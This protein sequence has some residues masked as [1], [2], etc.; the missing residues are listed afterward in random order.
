MADSFEPTQFGRYI[1]LDKLAVGGMAEIYRAKTYGVDGFEKLLA[2]K[3]IL[4]HCSADKDFITM[5]VDEA[6]L[7]VLLSHANIVQVYDLGKVG[8]DYFISMEFI[9]GT[10]LREMLNRC[11]VDDKRLLPEEV[12]VY[13]ISEICKGL[14]YAH[15]KTDNDGNPLNIVHRDVSPQNILISYEGEVKIVDFGIAKAALNV[16]HTM[17]GILKGKIA[18]MSPEQALGKPMDGRTDIFSAGLILYEALTGHKFFSGDTQFEVL[19]HIRSTHIHPEDLSSEIPDTLK[20]IL[21]KALAYNPKDR[22]QSAGDFQLD[23]TKFLYSTHSDFSPRQL[24]TLLSQLFEKELKEK[25]REREAS[26]DEKTRSVMIQSSITS[27]DIVVHREITDIRGKTREIEDSGLTKRE[28]KTR[29]RPF[30]AVVGTLFVLVAIGY[31]GWNLALK[32]MVKNWIVQTAS[33]P[34]TEMTTP[35][36]EEFEEPTVD[37]EETPWRNFGSIKVTTNPEGV[38]IFLNN[39]AT[40]LTSP[41]TLTK[42]KVGDKYA[43]RLSKE[44]Y[45]TIEETITVD[46]NKEIAL[47]KTLTPLPLGVI[48]ITSEPKGAQIFIN[49]QY[50]GQITPSRI[51]NLSLNTPHIVRLSLANHQDWTSSITLKNFDPLDLTAPLKTIPQ[52][53]APPAPTVGILT[54]QSNPEGARVSINGQDMG[55]TTPTSIA[56]ITLGYYY[57]IVLKREGYK[58]W[59]QSFKMSQEQPPPLVAN[60]EKIPE[61]SPQVK[62]TPPPPQKKVEPKPEP[63]YVSRSPEP[64]P[65]IPPSRIEKP[66]YQEPPSTRVS[67]PPGSL[68]IK[69]DPAGAEVYINSEYRGVT[70]LTVNDVSPGTVK[71][72][73]S[74]DGYLSYRSSLNLKPG[75][76]Q[77]LGDIKLG[78]RFGEV[79]IKSSPPGAIVSFDGQRIGARTPVTI[80]KVPRDEKHSVKIDLEGYQSWSKTFDL[81]TEA[82]KIY[83]VVL[84]KM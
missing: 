74:K 69:S 67:G 33:P 72:M 63:K 64:E 55:Q 39:E 31:L 35:P 42:L 80:R 50:T 66:V 81:N 15:R 18:Y 41:T 10:N 49:E 75:S 20:V 59:E 23:L 70:P 40:N 43:L 9:Y 17:A 53:T 46:S 21:A 22:Y 68:K 1:L 26:L 79:R 60:L 6:K 5:L 71:I 3:R 73:V 14:D 11:V 77:N 84:D 4:P 44:N 30:F 29:A 47:S 27:E 76:S 56:N 45:E 16:S 37:T 48:N 12:A 13:I 58:D 8:N 65:Y 51:D 62:K 83:N 24:S 36:A 2:I 7:T 19:E 78:S 38:S 82:E 61:P 57:N 28:E 25:K 52:P 34:G 54:L 32:K